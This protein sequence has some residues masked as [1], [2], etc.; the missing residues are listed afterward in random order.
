ML[1]LIRV[2]LL[3]GVSS[4]WLPSLGG[5]WRRQE[6]RGGERREGGVEGREE[7]SG[8]LREKRLVNTYILCIK[9]ACYKHVIS[10]LNL[11]IRYQ[12]RGACG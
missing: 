1:V 12:D 9:H 4:P 3:A 7:N 6:R 10:I 8:Q 11:N 2:W 5:D